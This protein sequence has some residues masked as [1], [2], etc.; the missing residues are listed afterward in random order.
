MKVLNSIPNKRVYRFGIIYTLVLITIAAVA[1][2]FTWGTQFASTIINVLLLILTIAM[3]TALYVPIPIFIK[4]ANWKL[5]DFGFVVNKGTIIISLGLALLVL[6]RLGVN[7]QLNYL[8]YALIDAVARVGEEVFFRG[9]IFTLVIKL[10]QGKQWSS[11]WAVVISSLAFAIVHTQTFLPSNHLTMLDIF[12]SSLLM[13]V[14]RY[15]TGSVLPGIIAHCAGNAGILGML[16][17]ILIY[18]LFILINYLLGRTKNK[19]IETSIEETR[20]TLD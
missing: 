20:S 1:N 11:F 5:R 12:I 16:A 13:G 4:T 17:G 6:F 9:F 7:L 3:W 18:C 8:Q 10:L 15:F 14:I 19:T 2:Y